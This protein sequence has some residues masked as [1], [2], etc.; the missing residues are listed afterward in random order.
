MNYLQRAWRYITRRPTK[1]IL[2]MITFFVIGNFV[3]LGLGISQA[4][5]NAK[6]LTRK[7][8]KAVVDYE[9]DSTKYYDYVNGLTDQDAINQAYKNYPTIDDAVAQE[10]A[11]DSRVKA[12]NYLVSNIMYS[13]DFDNVP[14]GNEE[15]NPTTQS[16]TDETGAVH[17]YTNPNITVKANLYP[18]MIELTDGTFS[19]VDGRFYS[20]DDI[21]QNKKVC[22]ITKEL[23]DQNNFHVGDTITLSSTDTDS[24]NSMVKAM[25][26]NKDDFY[27]SLEV[28]GIYTTTQD[29]DPNAENFKWMSP[30]D[31]PKNIVLMP[32]SAYGDFYA[33][34][35]KMQYQYYQQAYSGL[36]T[37][38]LGT[39]DEL[40][41]SIANI[42]KPSKVTYLL[43]DPL[44]VDKFVEDYTAKM[45]DYTRLNANNETFKK[46]ARPLDTLSF[47]S[48]IIVWIVTVNAVIIISLVTALTLKTRE[49]E[50]GVLL[51]IGVS[52]F[53]VVLQ[54]FL[55]LFVIAMLGFSL[56]VGSG[57]L[58]A[59]KV[60]ETVLNYQT[61]TDAQYNDSSNNSGYTFTDPNNYFT[62]VTQDDLLSQYHVSVSPLIIMEIYILGMGVV[63]IA[64]VIPSFMIMRLNPKQILLEQN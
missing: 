1:S 38:N 5:E 52:K 39:G 43:D 42:T 47:F 14:V 9:V 26:Y 7:S 22:L 8:M 61:T 18:N 17:T 46:L 23:A 34:V 48:N 62:E 44:N 15:T 53:K 32:L 27:L 40:D 57:S 41:Q 19:V 10:L 11:K 36:Q 58:I 60:G 3:I 21:D 31:S 30:S 25:G 28:V 4:A 29:V 64:I 20:Q 35:M 50:I 51:S 45:G 13:K 56:A 63:F 33:A 37:A 59:G 24:I 6:I 55:E 54:M 12:Y 49:F 16:Y 2:L